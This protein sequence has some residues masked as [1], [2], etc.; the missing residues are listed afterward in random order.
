MITTAGGVTAVGGA[1]VG[2][3]GVGGVGVG[4]VGVGGVGAGGVGAGGVGVAGAAVTVIVMAGEVIDSKLAV[5][6]VV[7]AATD[8]TKP[9]VFTVATDGLEL[10]QVASV[11]TF[12]VPPFDNVTEAVNCVVALGAWIEATGVVTVMAVGRTVEGGAVSVG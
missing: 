7:P 10:A 2:G 4:G 12:C 5:T 9:D 1:G 11:E 3:A 6:C 8:C